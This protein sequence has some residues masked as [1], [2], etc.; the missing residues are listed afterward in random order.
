MLAKLGEDADLFFSQVTF[1]Y[2]HD[3]SIKAVAKNLVDGAAV[4]SLI[5]DY[6]NRSNPLLT[7]QTR[8]ISKSPPYGI[9]PVVVPKELDKQLKEELRTVFLHMHEDSW[10]RAIL[11][12]IMIDRFIEVPDAIYDTVRTMQQGTSHEK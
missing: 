11:D 5:W 2:N 1:T 9:P 12:K 4:D 8:I 10:G 3:K 7:A 6:T